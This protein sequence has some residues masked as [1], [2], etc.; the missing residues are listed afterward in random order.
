MPG[1]AK[2][3]NGTMIDRSGECVRV[4]VPHY[5][6]CFLRWWSHGRRLTHADLLPHEVIARRAYLYDARKR[7]EKRPR[8]ADG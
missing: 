6:W 1:K 7:R 4:Y 3:P 2:V 5:G 8:C